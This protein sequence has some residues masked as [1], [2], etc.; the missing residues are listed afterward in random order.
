MEGEK[1]IELDGSKSVRTSDRWMVTKTTEFDC[2]KAGMMGDRWKV[3]KTIELVETKEEWLKVH[4]LH[5][6]ETI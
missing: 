3:S 5:L 6:S 4:G 2:T 1:A